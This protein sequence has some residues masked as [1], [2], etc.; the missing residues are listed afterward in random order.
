MKGDDHKPIWHPILGSQRS[1][2]QLKA[3]FGQENFCI[4]PDS[5]LRNVVVYGTSESDEV[6]IRNELQ[7]LA[8]QGKDADETTHSFVS[9]PDCPYF[10]EN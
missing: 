3:S 10:Y 2:D 5:R 1:S 8:K 7:T 6:R 4:C 9:R